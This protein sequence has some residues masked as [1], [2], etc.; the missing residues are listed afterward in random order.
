LPRRHRV[1]GA[2]HE[3]DPLAVLYS[4]VIPTRERHDV[5]GASIRAVLAQTRGNFELIVVDNASSPETRAVVGSFPDSRIRYVRAP[6][7]LAMSDNW[8]LGLGEVRG[9]Y[10]HFM[11][12]DDG[13]L[14]DAVEVAEKIHETWPGKVLTWAV[15]VY[16]WPDFYSPE[17]R[18]LAYIHLGKAIELRRS[19]E[20]LRNLYTYRDG[21]T[22]GELPSVYYSF[23]PRP[24]IER[25]RAKYGRYFLSEMPDVGS[26]LVNAWHVDDYLFSYRPL[27]MLGV[28]RHST[29]TSQLFP[30]LYGGPSEQFQAENA[31]RGAEPKPLDPRLSGAF[32]LEVCVAN[33]LLRF[34]DTYFP[35]DS[36]GPDMAG[37]LG[38][39]AR[40]MP[41][42]AARRAEV[43]AALHDMARKNRVALDRIAVP[44]P[45]FADNAT[46][47]Y[48]WM[49]KHETVNLRTTIGPHVRDI[50]DM[51]AEYA[52]MVVPAR[53]LEIP[54]K[55]RDRSLGARLW[56]G[57]RVRVP[58][59]ARR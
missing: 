25:L 29:G 48:Y 4:F 36:V 20:F 19:R 55:R 47:F 41:R 1:A 51:T 43:E 33:E 13:P 39:F 27:T 56:D 3:E 7:R 10:V 15:S 16:F 32:I 40:A 26:G 9:D 44:P 22:V 45:Q 59:V 21:A 6:E 23:V 50:A 34:R 58:R 12:D 57:L 53:D 42:L 52:R 24:L 17:F 11:G 30:D 46:A 54:R 5:L 14:P 31:T 37:W 49:G 28:S 18:N 38:W 2:T 8:E 35:D